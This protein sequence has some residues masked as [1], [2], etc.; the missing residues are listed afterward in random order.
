MLPQEWRTAVSNSGFLRPSE[1]DPLW[2][3]SLK[4]RGKVAMDQVL[5]SQDIFSIQLDQILPRFRRQWR[6]LI[7]NFVSDRLAHFAQLDW[8]E[9]LEERVDGIDARD[10]GA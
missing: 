8:E 6:R 3:P 10:Y 2:L 1:A 4:P 7:E 5:K 9:H